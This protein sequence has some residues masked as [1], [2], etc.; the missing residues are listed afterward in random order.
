MNTNIFVIGTRAQLIKVAP[1]ISAC[2][3]F[4]LPC[5]LL[6]TGQHQETMQD[7]IDEFG[8]R[9]PQQF[10][11]TAYER[12]T[13]FSLIAWLPKA[14]KGTLQKMK[15][16][17]A[18]FGK[19][20][21]NILV[22]GDTLTALI[23]AFCG[24]RLGLRVIHLESGLTSG[25]IF[26]PFPEEIVRRMV[27]RMTD[28]AICPDTVS[29]AHMRSISSGIVFNSGGNSIVDAAEVA[30]KTCAEESGQK[31]EAY[32]LF[33]I[34]RFQNIYNKPRLEEIVDLII[35]LSTKFGV[36]FILHPST[37]KRLLKTGLM[38]KLINVKNVNLS[39][40]MGY[41]DF[42]RL[43]YSAECV[44][45]DGGSN[46]EE[47]AYL[48]IPT[49]VMRDYTER[50]DGIDINA[51]M[52]GGI[53]EGVLDYLRNGKYKELRKDRH[54]LGNGSPSE[55]IANCLKDMRGKGDAA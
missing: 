1:I 21:L 47:L 35:K 6:M 2:E 25:K 39:D 34:H 13:V 9:S 37:K 22:H 3:K 8:V 16:L 45:T 19:E 17:R 51:I 11:T 40:R 24:R 43:A 49:I 29:E 30:I 23:S 20:S 18:S 12:A 7:L 44:L 36:F 10:V 28:I 31:K 41:G 14:Y 53:V 15:A 42:I 54:S 48:G 32:L 50:V 52:E 26:D 55:N 38:S 46:Q 33:S 27:F 4:E 5:I